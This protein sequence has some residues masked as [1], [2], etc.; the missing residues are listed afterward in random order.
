[1]RSFLFILSILFVTGCC[2]NEI[3]LRRVEVEIPGAVD[4][5]KASEIKS[6]SGTLRSFDKLRT[7]STQGDKIYQ[8]IKLREG[9][10]DTAMVA[11]FIPFKKLFTIKHYPRTD[12]VWIRDTIRLKPTD[13]ILKGSDDPQRLIWIISFT[14]T[15]IFIIIYKRYLYVRIL[16]K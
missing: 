3:V 10:K 8:G 4:T 2:G 12:T 16:K 11:E 1:M 9:S 6:E 15:T 7:G 13:I 5:L 14:L